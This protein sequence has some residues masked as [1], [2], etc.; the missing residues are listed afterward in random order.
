MREASI[1]VDIFSESQSADA[2]ADTCY[3]FLL[4]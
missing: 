4:S 2:D 3:S 1:E